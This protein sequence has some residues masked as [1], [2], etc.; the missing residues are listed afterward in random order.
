VPRALQTGNELNA[1]TL[2]ADEKMRRH[3][4]ATQLI[5]IR[6]RR[7]IELVQKELLDLRTTVNTGWKAD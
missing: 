6:V 2:A 7:H 1:L 5:E 4:Q 3:T